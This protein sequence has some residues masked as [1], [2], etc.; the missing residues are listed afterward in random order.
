MIKHHDQGHLTEGRIYVGLRFQRERER[1]PND[2]VARQYAPGVEIREIASS[3]V[4]VNQ[5]K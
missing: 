1:V 5:K 3:T 2:G 4:T